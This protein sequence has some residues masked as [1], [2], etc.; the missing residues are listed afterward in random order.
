MIE[1]N[2]SKQ[3]KW[4]LQKNTSSKDLI[5][6]FIE[7]VNNKDNTINY[8]EIKQILREKDSYKGRSEEGSSSTMGVRFS[9][10]C[11]YMFGYK[12]D[13]K[14]FPSPMI[15]LFGDNNKLS[16]PQIALICLYSMQFPNPYSKTNDNFRIF[17]GRLIIKLLL[18]ERL[19][20][21]LYIDE[22]IYFLMFLEEVNEEIYEELVSSIL[23]FR[24][25]TYEDK[26]RLF[27]SVRNYDNVFANAAH[28]MK[29]YFIKLFTEF[30]VF[31]I[32]GDEE[33]NEGKCFR[34]KHGNTNTYRTDGVPNKRYS[35]YIII[36]SKVKED[37]V[38]LN[39]NFSA[40]DL[41][42]IQADPNLTQYD[43]IRE[44]YE[45]KPL[46]YIE[47][48][49]KRDDEKNIMKIIENMVYHSENGSITGKTFEESLIPVFELFKENIKVDQ[50]SGPGDTDL[51]CKMCDDENNSYKIIVD[52]KK[53]KRA[54][55]QI[56]PARISRHILKNGAPYC[57]IV[58]SSFSRGAKY[59]IEGFPIVT[60]EAETLGDYCLKE[61]LTSDDMLADY[62]SLDKLIKENLGTDITEKV[63]ELIDIKFEVI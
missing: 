25:F 47:L 38:K 52:A 13:K 57:I 7:V 55:S 30:D 49:M 24:N 61:C 35:G 60:I 56:N 43:W 63:N 12:K 59:D 51:V 14:F 62:T 50:I 22:C 31:E 27:Q 32:I 46:K 41:P 8:D 36:N 40:F 48:I 15:R 39:D 33:H 10:I 37:A 16:L 42:K 53:R 45:F 21:K 20:E 9:Q 3:N 2:R 4:I 29:L 44:L 11:F 19:D 5:C 18:D 1:L 26:L 17:V 34:F 58:S 54:I 23:E 6:D 28:E